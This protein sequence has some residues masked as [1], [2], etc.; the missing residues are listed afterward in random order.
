MVSNVL[1]P[2]PSSATY[3]VCELANQIPNG[4][5]LASVAFLARA[6]LKPLRMHMLLV[7]PVLATVLGSYGIEVVGNLAPAA[8]TPVPLGHALPVVSTK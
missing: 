3:S 1:S 7:R 4:Y 6:V 8:G 2:A 5:E